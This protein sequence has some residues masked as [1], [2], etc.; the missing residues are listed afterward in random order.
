MNVLCIGRGILGLFHR[1][2]K[3]DFA[4]LCL[5]GFFC[6][7]NSKRNLL[8]RSVCFELCSI[9]RFSKNAD[10]IFTKT[11]HPIHI[12]FPSANTTN[13]IYRLVILNVTRQM[14]VLHRCFA[15]Q[16]RSPF[17]FCFW[18][19]RSRL[20]NLNGGIQWAAVSENVRR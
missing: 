11:V 16:F 1:C 20:Q 7:N 17:W 6:E 12:K 15:N 8:N 9:I 18:H 4:R 3:S 19:T 2:M 5:G 13:H 10:K 14:S